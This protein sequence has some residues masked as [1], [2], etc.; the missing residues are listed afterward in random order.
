MASA[1][2]R[3]GL[4]EAVFEI[5]E[6]F[7]RPGEGRLIVTGMGKSR[8]QSADRSP[9]PSPRPA[10]NRTHFYQLAP[11]NG[12]AVLD[13]VR[14]VFALKMGLVALAL[15]TVWLDSR[16]VSFVTVTLGSLVVGGS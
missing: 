9:P 16:L 11:D 1:T 10:R 8:A 6:N 12:F 15:A 3:H 7:N 2:L 5:A 13:I 14:R 4:G